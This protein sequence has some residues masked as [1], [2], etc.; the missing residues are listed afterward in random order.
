MPACTP[1]P[2]AQFGPPGTDWGMPC[3]GANGGSSVGVGA[4]IGVYGGTGIV[5]R[6]TGIGVYGGTGIGVYG[7]GGRE[8][9]LIGMDSYLPWEPRPPLYGCT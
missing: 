9:A 8:M 3:A 1:P 4:G 7:S 6:G 2:D 5:G